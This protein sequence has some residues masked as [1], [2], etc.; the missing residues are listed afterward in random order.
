MWVSRDKDV[1]LNLIIGK[2]IRWDE[3]QNYF[4]ESVLF[5]NRINGY[6]N[7]TWEDD[8][9]EVSLTTIK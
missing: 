6:E 9:V 2:P 3:I 4:S 8:P 7:L 1:A 5:F